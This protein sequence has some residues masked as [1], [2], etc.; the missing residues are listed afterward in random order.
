MVG[1][2]RQ[3]GVDLAYSG[4]VLGTLTLYQNLGFLLMHSEAVLGTLTVLGLIKF[5]G[6]TM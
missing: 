4:V 3:M 5:N 6:F 2:Q 1:L